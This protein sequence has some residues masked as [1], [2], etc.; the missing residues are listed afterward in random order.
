[1]PTG[2]WPRTHWLPFVSISILTTCLTLCCYSSFIGGPSLFPILLLFLSFPQ[3]LHTCLEKYVIINLY[4]FNHGTFYI[5]WN[6]FS[7][8][9]NVIRWWERQW[10]LVKRTLCW[11]SRD[12]CLDG[13]TSTNKQV[14]ASSCV[15]WWGLDNMTSIAPSSFEILRE[16]LISNIHWNINCCNYFLKIKT[17]IYNRLKTLIRP[18]ERR[19]YLLEGCYHMSIHLN[20]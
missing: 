7:S 9:T 15:S 13:T 3:N 2:H 8:L 19:M 5:E 14:C 1:M 10:T 4:N 20:I 11:E 12:L 6:V 16:Y 18:T 17:W